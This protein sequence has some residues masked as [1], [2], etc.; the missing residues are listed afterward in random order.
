[1]MK[2]CFRSKAGFFI[3]DL[4]PKISDNYEDVLS[5]CP[6]LSAFK[7]QEET[8]T[9]LNK[10]EN[11]P[12]IL[13][14]MC[15]IIYVFP[16]V[17][18]GNDLGRLPHFDEYNRTLKGQNVAHDLD[19][20][21]NEPLSKRS[22]I[23]RLQAISDKD[24]IPTRGAKEVALFKRASSGVV[25]VITNEGFGSGVLI[26]SDGNLLT[27]WH[28]VAGYK[29]VGVIFKPSREGQEIT[30]KDVRLAKVVRVDEISDLAL[31]KVSSVPHGANA[32]Q[33][34]NMKEVQ[35]GADVHA[36]GHPTGESWSY[37][38]GI[39]SQ[40]RTDYEWIT[41]DSK[42]H[43]ADVIQT[44]TPINPGNSGGPLLTSTGTV[45]GLNSF[46]SSGEGLNF[47]VSVNDL[48]RFLS[49]EQD[50]YA[51]IVQKPRQVSSKNRDCET[52][53]LGERRN[54]EN[55]SNLIFY[56]TNCDGKADGYLMVPDDTSKGTTLYIA[57]DEG[58]IIGIMH[59]ARRNDKWDW[60]LWD[61]QNS[62]KPDLICY[63][64]DGSAKPS[65]CE[66]YQ[67]KG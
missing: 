66:A 62:G 19:S 11:L 42:K 1:V 59:S 38:K 60:S 27:N 37:T 15:L 58:Q 25:M 53:V 22:F 14:V 36:I 45:I 30:R 23:N 31:L 55:N 47:A 50:R 35:I 46:K 10:G 49:R 51:E 41:K 5:V 16:V 54:K 44:Q 13:L 21:F 33:L 9:S 3:Q 8:M 4:I 7:Q 34:G 12:V 40:I 17:T 26:S 67:E 64:D 32:L 24:E 63:H 29:E 56:D 48:R 52:K 39:V 43:R 28:V 20:I 57:N 2:P 18:F 6:R 61:S 65:R